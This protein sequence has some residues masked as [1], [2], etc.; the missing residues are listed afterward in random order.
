MRRSRNSAARIRKMVVT[1]TVTAMNTAISS[2]CSA[3]AWLC[4]VTWMIEPQTMHQQP[5]VAMMAGECTRS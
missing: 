4:R 2:A 1:G 5:A 3:V